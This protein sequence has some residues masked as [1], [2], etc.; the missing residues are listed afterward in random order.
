MTGV[1]DICLLVE[2]G[3][4]FQMGGVSTWTQSFIRSFP[5]RTFHIASI[6]T[7]AQVRELKFTLPPNV[8]GVTE[9]LIDRP[10]Q[11]GKARL[12]KA[13]FEQMLSDLTAVAT[14]GDT[15]AFA[16]LLQALRETGAGSHE[17]SNSREAWNHTLSVYQK[18]QPGAPIVDFFWSWRFLT[19]SILTVSAGPL[20]EARMYHALSAGLPALMG[21]R[22]QI[23]TGAPFA[24]TEHGIYT[25]ER[26]INIATAEW[27]YRPAA[28][29]WGTVGRAPELHDLW[30]NAFV[31]AS[32]IGYDRADAITTQYREN[33]RFQVRDGAAPG[34]LRIIPNGID[35]VHLENLT[36]DTS[37]RRP[38]VALLGRLVPIK[39][40]RTFI[41]S[42]SYLRQKV[43]NVRMVL[44]GPE[45]EDP[46]YARDCRELVAQFDLGETVEFAGKVPNI[47]DWLTRI[48]LLAL[49]SISEA[50]PLALLEAGAVG[51]PAVTTDVGSCREILEGLPEDGVTGPGGLVVPTCDPEALADAMAKILNDRDLRANMSSAMQMRVKAHYSKQ[52]IDRLYTRLYA[53]ISKV[54]AHP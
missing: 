43:P 46:S 40:S 34:K 2:G 28:R 23:E 3:Y 36:V 12:S 30:M 15:A 6:F 52:R 42:A 37:A 32:R 53:D 1:A 21:A 38:T 54:E 29:G 45:D 48:D 13:R 9:V 49:T 44:I 39:D 17:L 24:I 47:E 7:S 31:S 27:L 19:D 18:L 14:N 10:P 50:Q 8:I 35:T 22:A 41:L 25:N 51:V 20:P 4:P 11:G 33:Q 16:T 26:R 5:D